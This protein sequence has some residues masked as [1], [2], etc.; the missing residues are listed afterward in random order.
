M[1][2]TFSCPCS[3][4]S[5]C[6]F[7]RIIPLS[8]AAVRST[9]RETLPR[10]LR[11]SDESTVSLCLVWVSGCDPYGMCSNRISVTLF[12]RTYR[13]VRCPH[14]TLRFTDLRNI[15]LIYY[16]F[17]PSVVKA[18]PEE[19]PIITFAAGVSLRLGLSF[20]LILGRC[21]HRPLRNV[22]LSNFIVGCDDNGM[23]LFRT[24]KEIFRQKRATTEI[25]ALY[26]V[27][28]LIT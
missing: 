10:A 24:L 28:Y 6:S 11:W 5:R 12:F 27:I 1:R 9:S 25:V 19:E 3:R 2:P 4:S 17:I 23:C 26:C 13:R 20:I 8:S 18:P 22:L 15:H 16:F 21:G 14:R 7:W